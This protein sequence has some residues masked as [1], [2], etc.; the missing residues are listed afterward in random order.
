MREPSP[1]E[2]NNKSSKQLLF[3]EHLPI[4]SP[5]TI[6]QKER[7]HKDPWH[8]GIQMASEVPF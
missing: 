4:D 7:D 5:V 2:I 8:K 6:S 1:R 3:E